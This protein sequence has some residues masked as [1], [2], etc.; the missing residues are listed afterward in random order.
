MPHTWTAGSTRR[1]RK[2]RAAQLKAEPRCQACLAQ[3][4]ITVA[5]QADH[6]T[7]IANGGDPDGPLQSLCAPCHDRKTANENIQRRCGRPA[8]IR[9]GVDANGWPEAWK[10]HH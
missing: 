4:F 2:R 5:T 8:R 6:I 3:G 10:H 7:P 9:Q 1:W